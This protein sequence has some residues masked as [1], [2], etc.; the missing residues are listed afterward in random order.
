MRA[1]HGKRISDGGLR[2][3]LTAAVG[4]VAA[5]TAVGVPPRPPGGASS[6]LIG[7][8]PATADLR[9]IAQRRDLGS[10]THINVA[11]A[12][13]DGAGRFVTGN[14]LTCM[15]DGRGGMTSLATLSTL[16]DAAHQA[17]VR[18]LVSVG[19]GVLPGCSGDWTALLTP[20]GRRAL[21]HALVQLVETQKLDGLDIDIEGALLTR[22]DKAGDFTPFVAELAQALH[23]RGKLLTCATASY[24]GGM[25]P[26]PSIRWFDLVNVMAYDRVGPTWGTPGDEQAPIEDA[27][28]ALALW[29]ARGV[30]KARLVLGVPFY[31]YGFGGYAGTYPTRDILARFAPEPGSDTVG[32]RCASCSYITFNGVDTLRR[33]ALLAREQGTGVMVWQIAGDTSDGTLLRA[34]R[35][36]PGIR[37]QAEQRISVPDAATAPEARADAG[38]AGYRRRPS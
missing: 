3:I 31:G 19:G 22:I 7:Y 16:V 10:Y 32:T 23:S 2:I 27:A 12:N 9:A 1:I 11:F 5:C 34:V 20:S 8:A 21:V 17:G 6:V 35:D 14:S 33:K 15:G 18:A 30:D 25:I 13:P 28:A 26:I 38:S 4:Q 37:D 24:E 29:R 36:R